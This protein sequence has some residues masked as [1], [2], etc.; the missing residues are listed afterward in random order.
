MGFP[1]FIIRAILGV[2]F[3]VV[4]SRIFFNE[5]QII[6]VAGLS[7]FLVGMAYAVEYFRNRKGS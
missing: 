2:A 3:S 4:I 6:N 1:I 5:I 7:I